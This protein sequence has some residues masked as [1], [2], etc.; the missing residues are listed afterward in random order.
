MAS[1]VATLP[2]R[3]QDKISV[4]PATGCW[5]WTGTILN[6][7]YPVISVGSRSDGSRANRRA[8]KFVWEFLGG[9]RGQLHH[10]CLRKRCVNPL[11]LELV[12]PVE[13]RARHPWRKVVCKRGHSLR[14]ENR[15]S[16]GGCREC[17]RLADRIK[18]WRK[19]GGS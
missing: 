1:D 19:K 18:Y 13:H 4:D 14:P 16:N 8:H 5:M 7:G 6:S 10:R 17:R 11:H 2:Q 15:D 9:A 12:V 3:V